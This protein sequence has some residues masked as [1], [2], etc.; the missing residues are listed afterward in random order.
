MV[1]QFGELLRQFESRQS[2]PANWR[3]CSG[4]AR[5]TRRSSSGPP[6]CACSSNICCFAPN[7]IVCT[8][9]VS[10]M[11][12]PRNSGT[13]SQR[14]CRTSFGECEPRWSVTRSPARPARRRED[15]TPTTIWPSAPR[16]AWHLVGRKVQHH[17]W[18]GGLSVPAIPA[19]QDDDSPIV[20]GFKLPMTA[21]VS[22]DQ[23]LNAAISLPCLDGR[24]RLG[25]CHG[26]VTGPIVGGTAEWRWSQ[27]LLKPG[28]ALCQ[29]EQWFVRPSTHDLSM[30]H[31]ALR[32]VIPCV[33]GRQVP[34]NGRGDNSSGC[35]KSRCRSSGWRSPD[36][37]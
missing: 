14:R 18:K 37:P 4:R 10:A 15:S 22:A 23:R 33:G 8:R 13:R 32:D 36:L 30:V 9:T 21:L 1:R 16:P 5:L 2:S 35:Q 28:R 6:C 12:F 19:T 20:E 11:R 24:N 34:S 29:M 27:H 31:V 26:S 25:V 7:S 3:P 17:V